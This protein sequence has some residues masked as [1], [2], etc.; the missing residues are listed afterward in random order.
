MSILYHP[1]KANIV[2][3]ALNRLS[4]G[5]TTHVEEEKR[6]LAKDVHRLAHLEVKEKQDQDPIFLELKA[7]V[8]KQK[9]LAFEQKGDGVLRYQGR[10]CVPM[11]DGLQD[12]IMEEAHSSRYSSHS[13]STK[14]YSDLRE[15]YWWSSIKKG[16]EEFVVNC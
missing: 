1:G 7:N 4:I 10:L 11:V 3:D 15:V 2:A 13:G 5:S 9:V 8:H 16:I 14:M 6:E 12:R